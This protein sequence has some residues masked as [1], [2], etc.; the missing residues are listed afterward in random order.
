MTQKGNEKEKIA[1][2]NRATV[3]REITQV[4]TRFPT[5]VAQRDTWT[6]N[7]GV[8]IPAISV[9]GTIATGFHGSVYQ[10]PISVFVLSTFPA[11]APVVYVRT[12]PSFMIARHH[13]A[14]NNNGEV[15]LEVLTRWSP[16]TPSRLV[17][18]MERL[19]VEFTSKPP[20]FA[21]PKKPLIQLPDLPPA[22]AAH[23]SPVSP[24]TLA[25]VSPPVR[26]VAAAQAQAQAP[27]GPGAFHPGGDCRPVGN[28]LEASAPP[29]ADEV[30]LT[31]AQIQ[32]HVRKI[33]LFSRKSEAGF[34]GIVG[35]VSGIFG[36]DVLQ[37]CMSEQLS[38]VG[39][40]LRHVLETMIVAGIVARF[41]PRSPAGMT[42][43]DQMKMIE[44]CFT[45]PDAV[46]CLHKVR[47]AGNASAHE[48]G[49][50][51]FN[52]NLTKFEKML[53]D[54]ATILS[55]L[56]KLRAPE[57]SPVTAQAQAVPAP[58]PAA[59]TFKPSPVPPPSP[60]AGGGGRGWAAPKAP[61]NAPLA[62]PPQRPVA[63]PA[64]TAPVIVKHGPT[65]AQAT[66]EHEVFVGNL[67]FSCTSEELAQ[68]FREAGC[69]VT[70][71]KVICHHETG[72]SK[73]FGYVHMSDAASLEKALTL[74]NR[75][76]QGRPLTVQPAKSKPVH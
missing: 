53:G 44:P 26:V 17:D 22:S 65:V 59:T 69:T 19:V 51:S 47:Q 48:K 40:D 64:A 34:P 23:G 39:R 66:V 61:P 21:I 63:T 73:G 41:F 18:V 72:A 75:Q 5:L 25:S 55:A 74:H 42:L 43:F 52:K 13:P 15:T 27:S 3:K 70:L 62:S 31:I 45:D 50:T 24:P 71:A 2:A 46:H 16:V 58:A 6:G 8:T 49:G 4:C 28:P 36:V 35:A 14:V 67:S 60:T 37:L 33:Q 30:L 54:F 32:L 20:L 9:N 7:D 12:P 38:Q 29:A 57:T 76:F 56:P 10:T 11:T 68:V 1:E